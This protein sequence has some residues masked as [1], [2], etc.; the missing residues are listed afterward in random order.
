MIAGC[1]SLSYNVLSN[2]N[3]IALDHN[4]D[5]HGSSVQSF[6][7]DI[8]KTLKILKMLVV[9]TEKLPFLIESACSLFSVLLV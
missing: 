7:F 2:K 5:S 8:G 4:I 3:S 9:V 1:L 6:K